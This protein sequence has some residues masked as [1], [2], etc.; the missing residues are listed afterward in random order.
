MYKLTKI[1][2]T[3]GVVLSLSSCAVVHPTTE[4]RLCFKKY[5]ARNLY[6]QHLN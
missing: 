3:S 5:A 4:S 2:I 1:L 6:K